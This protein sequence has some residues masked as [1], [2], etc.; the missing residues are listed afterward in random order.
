[1]ARCHD[2]NYIGPAVDS[3]DG[4]IGGTE[5]AIAGTEAK[6]EPRERIK[7]LEGALVEQWETAPTNKWLTAQVLIVPAG[8]T[9]K[10]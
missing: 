8:P 9:A 4:V 3:G 1:M 2:R 7:E 6:E 5:P 10:E